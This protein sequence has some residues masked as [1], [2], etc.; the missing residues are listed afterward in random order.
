MK[1]LS[2]NLADFSK[3]AAVAR[4]RTTISDRLIDVESFGDNPGNLRA[5]IY[6]PERPARKRALV[7]VLHGCTQD[8]AGY[9]IGAGWSCLADELGFLLLFPEQK[10]ANNPNLCFN[11]FSPEDN[12]RESGEALSIKQMIDRMVVDHGVAPARIFVTG[13]SAGG[14]MTSVMLATYPEL[15]A[16]GAIIAGLP[17][18]SASN[19]SQALDRMRGQG[20]PAPA[21]LAS[22]VREASPHKGPWPTISIWHGSAD[23]TVNPSNADAI[24][25]Q[26]R[27]IHGVSEAPSAVEMVE[28]YPRRIWRNADRRAV[29]EAYTITGMSHGTPLDTI[30]DP[31]SA[32]GPHMLEA[33]ISST[34]HIAAFWGLDDAVRAAPARKAEPVLEPELEAVAPAVPARRTAR[35]TRMPDPAP[36]APAPAT[37]GVGK[38]IEDALRAAGLMR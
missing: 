10:R 1:K 4:V 8:A 23:A 20:G 22:L 11:W 25:D 29:I 9:D 35:L 14:A 24:V 33:S 38:I 31:C 2:D 30:A 15:F 18:G 21:G 16:S 7:V 32:A 6:V 27:G 28:G 13:L 36:K 17:Y 26:W 5:R 37:Q 12:R 19:V 3:F 34:R